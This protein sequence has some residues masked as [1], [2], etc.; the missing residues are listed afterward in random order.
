MSLRF[1]PVGTVAPRKVISDTA[2]QFSKLLFATDVTELPRSIAVRPLIPEKAAAPIEVT[3]SG[4]ISTPSNPVLLNALA[5]ITSSPSGSASWPVRPVHP[6]KAPE[7]SSCK[8]L[9][10]S[11]IPDRPVQPE[12]ALF[13]IDSSSAG[14][15]IRFNAVQPENA[16]APIDR[17]VSGSD[18]LL[19]PF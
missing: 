1:S 16:Y 2:E 11:S 7:P 15:L 3:S 14:K 13:P 10:S 6:L 9:G 4:M 12:N 5:G 8:P 17:T 19:T 18:T